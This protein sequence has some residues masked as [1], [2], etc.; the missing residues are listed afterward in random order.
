MRGLT[1][2]FERHW[3]GLEQATT[4]DWK[5]FRAG[6]LAALQAGN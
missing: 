4:D 5:D 2:I 3:Y 6:Y 1:D